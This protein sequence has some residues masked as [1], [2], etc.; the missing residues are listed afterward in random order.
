MPDRSA[1]ST[2]A[3]PLT[4]KVIVSCRPMAMSLFLLHRG[5]GPR[6]RLHGAVLR[7][8]IRGDSHSEE[9]V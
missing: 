5:G 2:W 7:I 3:I 4:G 9:P 6:S 1:I 8:R